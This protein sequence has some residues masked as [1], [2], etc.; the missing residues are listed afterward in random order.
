MPKFRLFN[1]ELEGV[2]QT[3]KTVVNNQDSIP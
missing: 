1:E 3:V 2:E